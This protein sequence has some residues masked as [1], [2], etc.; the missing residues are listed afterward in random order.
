MTAGRDPR[1][2]A[3]RRGFTVVEV[4]I[5]VTI[6][7]AIAVFFFNAFGRAGQ[8]QQAQV[9]MST[10]QSAYLNL[11][12]ALER[13]LAGY[14]QADLDPADP[15]VLMLLR[16]NNETVEYRIE[17]DRIER[18]VRKA[19]APVGHQVFVFWSENKSLRA[20]GR[21][22]LTMKFDKEN[23]QIVLSVKLDEDIK[24]LLDLR[25]PV[26]MHPNTASSGFFLDAPGSAF[27]TQ[28]PP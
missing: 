8:A 10:V 9:L 16:P 1:R 24:P 27:A 28:T 18:T 15:K 26:P 23:D 20:G 17:A 7:A 14:Y 11:G 5:A 4:I 19:N 2:R 25:R 12:N 6:G 3:S 13:D 21:M 22:P